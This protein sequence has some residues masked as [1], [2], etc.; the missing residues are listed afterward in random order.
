MTVLLAVDPG[1]CSGYA[2]SVD[3]Q[4][5]ACGVFAFDPWGKFTYPSHPVYDPDL[6][7][8]EYPQVYIGPRSKGDPNDLIPLAGQAWATAGYFQRAGVRVHLVKPHAWKGTIDKEVHHRRMLDRE[9]AREELIIVALAAKALRK[10]DVHNMLDAV[11]L[12]KWGQSLYT[13]R[14]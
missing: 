8:V 9:L 4:I 14:N 6:V 3:G 11:A 13:G 12:A 10:G 1:R 7:V 5:R 2:Y